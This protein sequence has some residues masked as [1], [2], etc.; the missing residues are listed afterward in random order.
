MMPIRVTTSRI[1][2]KYI[3]IKQEKKKGRHKRKYN[4]DFNNNH[5]NIIEWLK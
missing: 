5:D 2:F 3:D 4:N 1:K